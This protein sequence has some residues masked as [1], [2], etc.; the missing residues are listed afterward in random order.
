MNDEARAAAEAQ[1]SE[2]HAM[3]NALGRELT[4]SINAM[5][6]MLRVHSDRNEATVGAVKKLSSVLERAFETASEVTL[7]LY[8]GEFYLN[9]TRL[10]VTRQAY[11]IFEEFRQELEARVLG[12]ISFERLPDA[13]DLL[14]FGTAFQAVESDETDDKFKALEQLLAGRGRFPIRLTR[15]VD[16]LLL[17]LPVL[18][19]AALVR[20]SYFRTVDAAYRAYQDARSGRAPT[21]KHA[22][23]AAQRLID[24]LY[25]EDQRLADLLVLLTDIKNW[26]DYESNHAANTT[27]LSLGLGMALGL[28]RRTLRRLGVAAMFADI[29]NAAM[30]PELLTKEGPLTD[31]DWQVIARHPLAAVPLLAGFQDVDN[32]LMDTIVT[33]VH[34]HKAYAGGGY[35]E[36]VRDQPSF[37]AQII[38]V[39]DRYDAMTTPRPYRPLPLTHPRAIELLAQAA[40][41]QLNPL[42]VEVF[43]RWIEQVPAGNVVILPNGDMGVVMRAESRLR[44]RKDAIIEMTH[45]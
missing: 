44:G 37:F 39:A 33:C 5:L 17:D 15:Y 36:T 12:A 28:D 16:T 1:Q 42:I 24:V 23:R 25:S 41:T 27:V 2:R 45:I 38:A 19:G 21:I 31:E 40:G 18:E 3:M 20:Q 6:R 4:L 22:K 32:E 11:E 43:V 34:H 35:P 29:G 10:K 14:A 13:Q 7:R 30:P 9:D 8:A 26:R